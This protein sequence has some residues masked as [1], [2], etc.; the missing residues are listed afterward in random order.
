MLGNLLHVCFLQHR[1]CFMPFTWK[2]VTMVVQT[3]KWKSFKTLEGWKHITM[4]FFMSSHSSFTYELKCKVSVWNTICMAILSTWFLVFKKKIQVN[5][6]K[7]L[8]HIHFTILWI[9]FPLSLTTWLW[10]LHCQLA[11]F[12]SPCALPKCFWNC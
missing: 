9:P 10:M 8:I 1:L 2:D 4:T 3:N 7:R 12:N 6:T 11:K 5:F